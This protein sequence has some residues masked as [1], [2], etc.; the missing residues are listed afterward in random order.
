MLMVEFMK[1]KNWI[2]YCDL[3]QILLSAVATL[4]NMNESIQ[5]TI[6]Y[7]KFYEEIT[8]TNVRR[9]QKC[10]S[11]LNSNNRRNCTNDN[12]SSE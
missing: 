10:Y 7:L 4:K 8:K 3:N 5:K 11:A 12:Y 6:E 1:L 9:S 2:N